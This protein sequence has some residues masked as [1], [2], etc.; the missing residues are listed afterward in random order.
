MAIFII[1]RQHLNV[2]DAGY[3]YGNAKVCSI[4][5]KHQSLSWEKATSL[6]EALYN[7]Q[8]TDP[9]RVL[10]PS[11]VVETTCEGIV[12]RSVD[13]ADW[14]PV[15]ALSTCVRVQCKY[16]YDQKFLAISL[17]PHSTTPRIRPIFTIHT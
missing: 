12:K 1:G 16:F 9:T 11:C 13:F 5:A 6:R 15:L 3:S 2:I 14:Q 17:Q 8:N 7:N 10:C 4:L